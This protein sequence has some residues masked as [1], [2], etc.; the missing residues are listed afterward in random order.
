[1]IDTAYC[2]SV[3]LLKIDIYNYRIDVLTKFSGMIHAIRCMDNIEFINACN[4]GF[5][6]ILQQ[7]KLLKKNFGP[8]P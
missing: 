8:Q 4:Y 1:M 5:F 3:I 2:V 6:L 7:I